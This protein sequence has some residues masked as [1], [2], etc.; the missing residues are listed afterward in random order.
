MWLG[1]FAKLQSQSSKSIFL[2]NYIKDIQG[3]FSEHHGQPSRPRYF[4]SAWRIFR[5]RSIWI[6]WL[7]HFDFLSPDDA[8]SAVNWHRIRVGRAETFWQQCWN[9][10]AHQLWGQCETRPT[11]TVVYNACYHLFRKR[12]CMT[13]HRLTWASWP[14]QQYDTGHL[15]NV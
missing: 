12:S 9:K 3:P 7:H 2:C 1:Y 15:C 6:L 11:T 10:K 5:D 14:R 4:E 8:V 13:V